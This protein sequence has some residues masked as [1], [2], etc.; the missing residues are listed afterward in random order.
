VLPCHSLITIA[1]LSKTPTSTLNASWG[2]AQRLKII[3]RHKSEL[4]HSP[5]NKEASEA[6]SSNMMLTVVALSLAAV[7]AQ[8]AYTGTP[9]AKTILPG[10]LMAQNFDVGGQGVAFNKVGPPSKKNS[11]ARTSEVS[12]IDV[13]FPK[14]SEQ[15]GTLAIGAISSKD[16]LRYTVDVKTAAAY[17]P[18]WRVAAYSATGGQV[19]VNTSIVVGAAAAASAD[20]C[21]L[22]GAGG[23]MMN[24]RDYQST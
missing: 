17:V 11:G 20:P 24:V 12:I 22:P 8:S 13:A 3:P 16:W 1:E 10:T 21:S 15:S 23:L 6:S 9:Y 4:S 19:A 7:C 18:N 2:Y 5:L 14:G